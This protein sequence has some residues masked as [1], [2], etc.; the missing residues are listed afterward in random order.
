MIL[1]YCKL[2]NIIGIGKYHPTPRKERLATPGTL[3]E[4]VA[5][6]TSHTPGTLR[7]KVWLVGLIRL[8]QQ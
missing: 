8:V 3:R 7:E 4:C 5:H 6:E 2:V 1:W